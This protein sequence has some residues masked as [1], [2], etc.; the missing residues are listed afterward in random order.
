MAQRVRIEP[1][2]ILPFV[3]DLG[4][5]T[6]IGICIQA[7]IPPPQK[8]NHREQQ[9]CQAITTTV[10]K[11]VAKGFILSAYQPEL[12]SNL[13]EQMNRKWPGYAYKLLE[14]MLHQ[15]ELSLANNFAE[16]WESSRAPNQWVSKSR[17]TGTVVMSEQRKIQPS[18]VLDFI[19]ELGINNSVGMFDL[20]PTKRLGAKESKQVENLANEISHAIIKGMILTHYRQELAIA[21]VEQMNQEKRGF[22]D[23]QLKEM[24][25]VYQSFLYQKYNLHL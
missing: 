5:H 21:A 24:L 25:V 12:P 4:Y 23:E 9:E 6:W 19:L 14:E 7:G 15:Y 2:L 22:A 11:S 8:M 20:D 3:R 13:F 17:P 16:R 1:S 18:L 10:S